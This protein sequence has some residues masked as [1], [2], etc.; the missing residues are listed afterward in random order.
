MALLSAY[1]SRARFARIL[2]HVRGDVLDIGC[3]HGQLRDHAADRI[4]LYVGIDLLESDIE[5]AR[6]AHPDCEF[7]AINVDDE[8]LG[9]DAAFDTIV[10][11]AVI[12]H[13]FNLKHLGHGLALALRP[14]GRVVLTTPTPFGNDVIHRLGAMLGLFSQVAADDHIV[15]FNRKRLEIFAGEAGLRL[16]MHRLFQL[17]CNQLAVIEKP[18]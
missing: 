17:G 3:Q 6:R 12:E 7:K 10:M 9:Y 11:C 8:P 5:H 15:I 18:G 2:P 1:L 13:I 14:G 16:V 4:N